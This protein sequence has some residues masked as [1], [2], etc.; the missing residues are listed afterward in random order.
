MALTQE[1]RQR[2]G[3]TDMRLIRYCL[4]NVDFTKAQIKF[5]EKLGKDRPKLASDIVEV[6]R[7]NKQVLAMYQKELTE[8]CQNASTT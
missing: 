6:I 3:C 4:N 8:L 7:S 1:Q 5:Y 2:L